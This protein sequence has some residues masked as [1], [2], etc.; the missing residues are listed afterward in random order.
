MGKMVT[1]IAFINIEPF[2]QIGELT[3]EICPFIFGEI[4]RTNFK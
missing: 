3:I 4:I 1:L 2:S